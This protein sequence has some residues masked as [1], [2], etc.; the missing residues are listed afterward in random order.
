[1]SDCDCIWEM[2]AIEK[3]MNRQGH[4][5]YQIVMAQEHTCKETKDDGAGDVR[6]ELPKAE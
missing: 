6:S 4:I 5:K 2:V 3:L 1:M